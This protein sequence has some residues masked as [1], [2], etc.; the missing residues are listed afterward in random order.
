MAEETY[1]TNFA[2]FQ[3]YDSLPL[4]FATDLRRAALDPH[5]GLFVLDEGELVGFL[6]SSSA[7]TLGRVSATAT[8]H[9]DIALP[10][11][12]GGP[13]PRPDEQP[14]RG[15]ATMRIK[16]AR[17]QSQSPTPTPANFLNAA[18]TTSRRWEMEKDL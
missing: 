4:L 9:R 10:P 2:D 5:H 3:L 6:C 1:S 11:T 17:S 8:S 15:F 14:T 12:Q 13:R 18:A 7:R 16:R